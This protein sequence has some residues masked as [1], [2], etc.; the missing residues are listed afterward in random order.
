MNLLVSKYIYEAMG[1]L[2][3]WSCDDMGYFY[4][5]EALKCI[6]IT[7]NYMV[8]MVLTNAPKDIHDLTKNAHHCT[9]HD[10]I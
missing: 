6:I 3:E 7:M 8:S 9:D 10:N 2:G 1:D 5:K 4:D